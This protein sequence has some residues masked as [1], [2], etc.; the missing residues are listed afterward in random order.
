[1]AFKLFLFFALLMDITGC[2]AEICVFVQTG[3]SV[4]LDI[5]TQEL[6][7]FYVLF[8][9]NY[10]LENIVTYMNKE[11]IPHLLYK[12]RVDFNT[13]T[14]SLTLKNMQKTDS[15]LYRAKT[16]GQSEKNI[17]TYRVSVLDEVEDPVLAVNSSWSSPDPCCFTCKGSNMFISSISNGSSCSKEEVASAD[18]H[19]LRLSCSGESIMCHYSNPVSLK[20]QVKKVNELCTFEKEVSGFPAWIIVSICLFTLTLAAGSSFWI[21][22][23]KKGTRKNEQT[24]Y[25]KVNENIKP[26]KSLEMLEKSE[27]PHTEFDTARDLGQSEDTNHTTPN[28]H[29]MNQSASF[30]EKSKLNTPGTIYCLIQQQPKSTKTENDHTIYASVNKVSAGYESA[31][32]QS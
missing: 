18:N 9:S 7:E 24:V 6:P 19:T 25:A 27:I 3:A 31:H 21:Y 17:V 12:D 30:T 4:Q 11:V 8:W 14:F 2:S 32:P 5:Q 29:P 26:Q 15:G 23:E 13:T 10:K 16:N 28:D 20:S 22:K 1:M